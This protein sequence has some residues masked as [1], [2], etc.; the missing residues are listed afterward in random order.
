MI[1]DDSG[2]RKEFDIMYDD[3]DDSFR[4]SLK[5]IKLDSH[6][7]GE[8]CRKAEAILQYVNK[9]LINYAISIHLKPQYSNLTSY[10]YIGGLNENDPVSSVE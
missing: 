5:A 6:L 7:N 4:D 2:Y 3:E 10:Y 9:N 8:K 1:L